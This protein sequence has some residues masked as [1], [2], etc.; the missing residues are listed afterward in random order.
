MADGETM[1]LLIN[2]DELVSALADQVLRRHLRRRAF[3]W[4]NTEKYLYKCH[5]QRKNKTG[6]E[7]DQAFLEQC[8][9]QD[10]KTNM[11]MGKADYK[12][13]Y[14][15]LIAFLKEKLHQLDIDDD[16][17]LE[18][19]DRDPRPGLVKTVGEQFG[20]RPR[21]ITRRQYN[22][23]MTST[24]FIRN[25]L[26]NEDILQERLQRKL[27]FWFMDSGYTNF[28][29]G[30]KKFHRLVSNHLHHSLP[31]LEY[32]ADRLPTLE[33]FPQPWQKQGRKILVVESSERHYR[34]FDTTLQEWRSRVQR[35]L[36]ESTDR[37]VLW[38]SKDDNKKTRT[39]VWDMLAESPT[40]WYCVITDASAAALEAIW[41]GIPVITLNTHITNPVS[42]S[43]IGMIDNL[44]RGP[45][46]DWL[47]ALSY[48]QF[49][50]DEMYDGTAKRMMVKYHGL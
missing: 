46:G 35:Q 25:T 40:D 26:D 12:E 39:S 42:R 50:A 45:I 16:Q 11:D 14:R 3:V 24:L 49:T 20:S 4:P 36:R 9:R 30:R 34:L 31:H 43:D 6:G 32:P 37:P 8:L 28:L 15:P 48:H 5:K 23:R 27:P 17:L 22:S 33:Q 19:T 21:L 47:C 29:Y 2:D 41:L 1:N 18:M 13:K 44:Y 7:V 38:K 10:V